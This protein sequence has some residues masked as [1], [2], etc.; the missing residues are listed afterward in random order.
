MR[1]PKKKNACKK[2]V[3]GIPKK[4]NFSIFFALVLS[5]G[6]TLKLR[7]TAKQ[8]ERSFL[9]FSNGPLGLLTFKEKDKELQKKYIC[10]KI[11]DKFIKDF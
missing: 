5:N 8:R 11:L 9:F 4:G 10:V 1:V 6:R 3:I 2:L 7:V